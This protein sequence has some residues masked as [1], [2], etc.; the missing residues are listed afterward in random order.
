[1]EVFLPDSAQG[2]D[3][4]EETLSTSGIEPLIG[5]MV[6][7]DVSILL[8]KFDMGMTLDITEGLRSLGVVDAFVP[9]LADFA[10]MTGKRDLFLSKIYQKAVISLSEEGVTASA[11]GESMMRQPASAPAVIT[12]SADHP[13]TFLIWN[14]VTKVVLFLGHMEKPTGPVLEPNGN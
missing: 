8:P 4:V 2:L 13:F 11:S 10:G 6:P 9:D 3:S 14:K 12:F 1:M 5:D 7:K